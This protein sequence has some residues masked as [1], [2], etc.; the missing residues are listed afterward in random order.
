M[1]CRRWAGEDFCRFSKSRQA[2]HQQYFGAPLASKRVSK[3]FQVEAVTG[4]KASL[5]GIHHRIGRAS[6][7]SIHGAP[8]WHAWRIPTR[9]PVLLNPFRPESVRLKGGVDLAASRSTARRTGAAI[10]MG[11]QHEIRRR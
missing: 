7:G 4:L 8:D 9:N 10:P 2:M 1:A 5:A 11:T 6:G 3:S